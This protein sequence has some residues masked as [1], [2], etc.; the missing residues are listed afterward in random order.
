MKNFIHIFATKKSSRSSRRRNFSDR[1]LAFESMENRSLMSATPLSVAT[2]PVGPAKPS[3]PASVGTINLISVNGGGL[4]NITGNDAYNDNVTVKIDNRGTPS[5]ADDLVVVSLTNIGTPLV[6]QFALSAVT[7]ISFSG[8]AGNDRFQN[9]TSIPSSAYGGDG[10][11]TLIGGS[12]NDNLQGGNGNDFLDGGA[13]DDILW[14][15]A[16]NDY[17]FGDTGNDTLHGG[18][19]AD[20]LFGG[21]G[22]DTLLGENGNDRLEGGTGVDVLTGG[23]GADSFFGAAWKTTNTDFTTSQGDVKLAV[24]SSWQWFDTNLTDPTVRSIARSDYFQDASL[25]RSDFLG[26]YA[27]VGA[28]GTVSANELADLQHLT[29]TQ[30][31]M[32]DDVRNLATK[33]AGSNDGNLFYQNVYLGNLSAGSSADQLNMLV[34]KWFL[35]GDHPTDGTNYQ[36]TS[37][38]LFQNGAAYTDVAQGIDGDCYFLSSLASIAKQDPTA[39]TSM[40][41]D[42]GDG[43]FTVRF[44]KN[45]ITDYVTVDRYLPINSA[46]NTTWEAGIGGT[47]TQSTNEL[48]V[49][50]AEKAYAQLDQEGWLRPSGSQDNTYS[51]INGGQPVDVYSQLTGRTA[52]KTNMSTGG[53]AAMINAFQSGQAVALSTGDGKLIAAPA[54]AN[55]VPEH[56]Y[57]LVGYN[58]LTKTFT[59]ANPWGYKDNSSVYSVTLTLTWSQICK[60]FIN[61]AS[62][63]A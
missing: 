47:Y 48:W 44:Y 12:G 6:Q 14:G 63:V 22:N 30:L 54:D 20:Q 60:D 4:L 41:H 62:V 43:T 50:L 17:L 7:S 42:N 36:Y 55:V 8:L 13:G 27:Q 56:C 34:D 11:D 25:T 52:T 1:R 53:Q 57:A 18:D 15:Q 26:I 49:A 21:A 23:A 19:D 61:W 29:S 2:F 38:S 32:A 24:A 28:D 46:N 40:F 33:L 35:G 10:N 31:T 39:I 16:G 5:P 59:I 45:G 37:G 9:F 58:S 3:Q 51:S